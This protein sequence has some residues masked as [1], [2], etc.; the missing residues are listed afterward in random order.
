ML[1][2]KRRLDYKR[3]IPVLEKAVQLAPR[4]NA[5]RVRVE[6]GAAY[7]KTGRLREAT[8]QYDRVLARDPNY[9]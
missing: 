9:G 5:D 7:R 3:A 2:L 6:P 1:T 8:V 4:R